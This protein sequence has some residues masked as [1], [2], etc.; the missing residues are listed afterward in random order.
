MRRESGPPGL[1]AQRRGQIAG[2]PAERLARGP[3]VDAQ[4]ADRLPHRHD[5]VA[6]V[7]DVQGVAFGADF[8]GVIAGR[9]EPIAKSDRRLRRRRAGPPSS[10]RS[11]GRRPAIRPVDG[12]AWRPKFFSARLDAKRRPATASGSGCAK[13][14]HGQVLRRGCPRSITTSVAAWAR[15][16]LCRRNSA[17]PPRLVP[18]PR[19]SAAGR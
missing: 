2:G 15:A 9:L 12:R 19:W 5:Q 11:G 18:A 10:R 1:P 8:D 6:V 17:W 13:A 16:W 4:R 14:D 3:P 7:V